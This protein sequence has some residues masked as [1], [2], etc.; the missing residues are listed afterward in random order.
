MK[1]LEW[2]SKGLDLNPIEMFWPKLKQ[3]IH[4]QKLSSVA[5][6]KQII[7]PQ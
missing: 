4:A 1:V 7:L 3:A 2:P 5:D 6:L